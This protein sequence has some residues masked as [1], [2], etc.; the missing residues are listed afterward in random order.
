MLIQILQLVLSIILLI[1]I[2]GILRG[3]TEILSY[4]MTLTSVYMLVITLSAYYMAYIVKGITTIILVIMS[5]VYLIVY[6]EYIMKDLK[7]R[8][9]WT[10]N[11][12]LKYLII[13][14]VEILVLVA[15]YIVCIAL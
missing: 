6:Y 14:K 8:H 15:L 1:R 9:S 13:E 11:E 4:K 3:K 5:S 2:G 10:K 7:K 12:W